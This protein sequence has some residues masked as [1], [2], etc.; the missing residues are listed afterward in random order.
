MADIRPKIA[1]AI[2]AADAD[3]QCT[4]YVLNDP[5]SSF[6]DVELD[7]AGVN[8]HESFENGVT[9]FVLLIRGCIASLD[10][11]SQDRLDGWTATSGSSSIQAAL[12]ADQSLGGVAAGVR[13]VQ[14]AGYRAMQA[15]GKNTIYLGAEWTVEIYTQG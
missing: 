3:V 12:E 14:V 4:G 5:I 9:R 2:N 15:L 7:P 1:E 6:F 11:A 8:P 13:V 10:K